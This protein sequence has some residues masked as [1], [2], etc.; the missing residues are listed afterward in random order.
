MLYENGKFY[1]SHN[2]LFYAGKYLINFILYAVSLTYIFPFI[3]MAYTSFKTKGEFTLDIFSF[4]QSPSLSNLQ[5]IFNSRS[6]V[7]IAI[8]N[9]IFYTVV[10]VFF[11][12][13]FSFVISYI[14]SRYSFKGRKILYSF[15]LMGILIPVSSLLVPIYMQFNSIGL[16]NKNFT[17][18]IPYITLNLPTAIFLFSSYISSLSPAIDEAAYVDGANMNTVMFK[19]MFPICMP[20]V[21]TVLILNIMGIWNEFSFA[22]VLA[23]SEKCRTIP[24]WLSTFDSQFQSNITAKVTAMFLACLPII[25][26]YTLFREKIIN[27]VAAGAI[28]G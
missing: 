21:A 5:L 23:S 11:I 15:F 27:G 17:L 16:T 26:V 25:I 7:Y 13:L 2:I 22:L 3:W 14:L 6:G 19:I 12:L 18:L 9:S 4:P 1:N 28:K 20:I 8:F 10:S 24:V